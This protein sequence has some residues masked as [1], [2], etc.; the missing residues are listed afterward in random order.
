MSDIGQNFK[1]WMKESEKA[2]NWIKH[3]IYDAAPVLQGGVLG[4]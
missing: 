1:K 4:V 2:F 3:H